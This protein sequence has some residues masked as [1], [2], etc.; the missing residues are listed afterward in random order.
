MCD[1]LGARPFLQSGS[2]A[3]RTLL[4]DFGWA[5]GDV[6]P[7]LR[8]GQHHGKQSLGFQ[9]QRLIAQVVVAHNGII[10]GPFNTKNGHFITPLGIHDMKK[11]AI[12]QKDCGG[13]VRYFRLRQE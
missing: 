4:A 10:T 11:A 12:F 7:I 6:V 1:V 5:S 9:R 2:D 8:Q 3:V 13:Q